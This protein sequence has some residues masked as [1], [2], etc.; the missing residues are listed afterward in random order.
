MGIDND[1]TFN[2]KVIL[3]FALFIA[4]ASAVSVPTCEQKNVVLKDALLK[5]AKEKMAKA[6]CGTCYGDILIAGFCYR[7]CHIKSNFQ[8]YGR[9]VVNS[10][11]RSSR[12]VEKENITL[13]RYYVLKAFKFDVLCQK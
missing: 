3:A 13:D 5:L 9:M 6:D 11:K 2:M 8:N 1:Q 4:V 10:L 12:R 7:K